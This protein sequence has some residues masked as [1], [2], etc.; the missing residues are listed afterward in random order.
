MGIA[1][2]PIN[3]I[4]KES[5]AERVSSDATD[6]LVKYLEEEAADIAKKAIGYAKLAKRQTVKAEDIELAIKNE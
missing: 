5:G 2:A 3:R 1:K 6:T 4:I